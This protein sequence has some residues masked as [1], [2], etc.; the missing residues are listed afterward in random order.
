MKFRVSSVFPVAIFSYYTFPLRL[1]PRLLDGSVFVCVRISRRPG[2]AMHSVTAQC[3][4]RAGGNPGRAGGSG[5][6]V[7]TGAHIR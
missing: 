6:G 3:D 4:L 2:H 1:H 7:C 5:M